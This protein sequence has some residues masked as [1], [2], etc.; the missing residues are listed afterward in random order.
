MPNHCYQQVRIEGPHYLVSMLYNGLT[1]N[2]YNPHNGGRA[3]NPQFCQLVCPMPF[4]QWQAPKAKWRQFNVEGWYD[5][6]VNNWGTKWDVCEVEIDE[7][8][9][10]ETREDNGRLVE[11][12]TRSWFEFRCW[13]A[14]GPPVPVWDKLHEL[15]VKVHATYQDEGGMFEGEYIDGDDTTWTP[16]DEEEMEDA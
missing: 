4:E 16:E 8:L 5:W 11:A 14:W 12:D 7:E 6:R 13:T 10:H 3:K 15:G 1:E 2:G 9:D